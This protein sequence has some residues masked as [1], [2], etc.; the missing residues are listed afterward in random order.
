MMKNL[1][2]IALVFL[3]S[4]AH[5][6]T[7][8]P[9][10][11]PSVKEDVPKAKEMTVEGPKTRAIFHI[12]DPLEVELILY[13]L[14]AKKEVRI[15]VERTLSQIELALGH[16]ELV[17]FVWEGKHFKTLNSSKRYVF[18]I[19]PKKTSYVG[20]FILKCPKVD[21]EYLPELKKMRFFNRYPVS[22][23][24]HLC[25]MVVGNNYR[26]VNR[27]WLKVGKGKNKPLTLGF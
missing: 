11:A 24:H 13:H 1:L 21:Q 3:G 16:W 2:F 19:R 15:F 10:S 22:F 23:D 25:E 8:V 27:A 4:C 17:G 5:K 9:V 6:K 14:E 26:H 12:I 18:H 7:P 20:S